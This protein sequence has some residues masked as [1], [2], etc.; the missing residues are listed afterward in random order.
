M[1]TYYTIEITSTGRSLGCSSE[2]YQIFD[3]Q[4]NH[5]TT[6]EAVKL[7]LE[8]KYGNYERQKIFRDTSKGAEHIGWVYCFNNDDIS[9]TPVDKWHQRDYVEVWKNE[10]TPVIV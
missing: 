1:K 9:H 4:T 7:H 3:R 6:L 10:A 5:F 8:N 2:K